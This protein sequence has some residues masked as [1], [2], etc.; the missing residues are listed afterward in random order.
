MIGIKKNIEVVISVPNEE[1]TIIPIARHE[2]KNEPARVVANIFLA[3]L[4]TIYELAR[5]IITDIIERKSII[6][7]LPN[8]KLEKQFTALH[9]AIFLELFV[10]LVT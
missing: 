4:A 9:F 3:N 7:D 2:N 10:I 8:V 6:N 1:S 5:L